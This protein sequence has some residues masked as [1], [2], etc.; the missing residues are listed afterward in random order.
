MNAI[1]TVTGMVDNQLV[2]KVRV[3]INESWNHA[4][5]LQIHHSFEPTF[6]SAQG[7]LASIGDQVGLAPA[8][9]LNQC[10]QFE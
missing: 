5:N 10:A 7:L 3:V 2:F 1:A 9:S 4:E 6:T 8:A